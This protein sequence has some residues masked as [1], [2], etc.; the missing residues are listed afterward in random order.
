MSVTAPM[1]L[2][3]QSGEART[4]GMDFVNLL[5]SGE[6][7]ASVSSVTSTPDGLT[8]GSGSISG[9]KVL[10]TVSGGSAGTTYRFDFTVVTSASQTLIA[11]GKLLVVDQ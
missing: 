8:V 7:I 3:K 9:T 2:E 10:V 5:D 4:V 6:T 11:D 1:I